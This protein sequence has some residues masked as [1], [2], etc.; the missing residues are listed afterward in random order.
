MVSRSTRLLRTQV[1]ISS[2]E[3]SGR[4]L[5]GRA[6]SGGVAI[7]FS[8]YGTANQ[9][10]MKS[11]RP[12]FCC[13][14]FRAC[15]L[16]AVVRSL[17]DERVLRAVRF[18]SA[19]VRVSR[20]L[21]CVWI[22]TWRAGVVCVTNAYT[23][24][25]SQIDALASTITST[26]T[27]ES[28]PLARNYI[29]VCRLTRMHC[30][31]NRSNAICVTQAGGTGTIAASGVSTAVVPV[32]PTP[33]PAPTPAPSESST[34]AVAVAI[35]VVVVVAVAVATTMYLRRKGAIC[36]TGPTSAAQRDQDTLV[37]VEM[38][39]PVQNPVFSANRTAGGVPQYPSPGVAGPV[40][41]PNPAFCGRCGEV[42]STD[43]EERFCRSCGKVR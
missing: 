6:L 11:Y 13:R 36:A 17:H 43:P 7:T 3:P 19:A 14:L 15:V 2:I 10:S 25:V 33:T 32:N 37:A 34:L 35:P 30:V 5:L 8:V 26:L 24:H 38:I 18:V 22:P 1:V 4:L 12:R 16:E 42:Y 29:T 27:S 31:A 20:C 28:S 39:S 40:V 41:N 9:V 21:F 23:R